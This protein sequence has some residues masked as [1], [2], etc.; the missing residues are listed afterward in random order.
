MKSRLV[1]LILLMVLSLTCW[2]QDAPLVQKLQQNWRGNA[3]TTATSSSAID[4]FMGFLFLWSWF[5]FFTPET[6][7][8]S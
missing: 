8:A 1:A 4:T 7:Q 2:A 6:Q 3:A 5:Y